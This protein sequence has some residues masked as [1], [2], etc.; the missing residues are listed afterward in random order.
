MVAIRTYK[1]TNSDSGLN[2]EQNFHSTKQKGTDPKCVIRIV[3]DPDRK[4]RIQTGYFW[5]MIQEQYDLDRG[6]MVGPEP[7]RTDFSQACVINH[8]IQ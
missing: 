4:I 3:A 6:Y 2:K 8:M 7:S 5:K 1:E